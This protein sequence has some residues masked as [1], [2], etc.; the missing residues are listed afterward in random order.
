MEIPRKEEIA[1][2]QN[3]FAIQTI[4]QEI[5]EKYL[6]DRKRLAIREEVGLLPKSKF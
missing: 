4:R 2:A 5:H 6:E 1:L 3:Y